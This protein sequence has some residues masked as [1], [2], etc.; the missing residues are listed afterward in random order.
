MVQALTEKLIALPFE[1]A[2][3]TIQYVMTLGAAG[4]LAFIQANIVEL[5]VM[6]FMRVAVQPVNFRLQRVLKFRISVQ[7]AQL[8]GSPV[9]IMTPELEAIGLMSDMLRLMYRFSVDAL[10]SVISPIAVV[11]IYLFKCVRVSSHMRHGRPIP[12]ARDARLARCAG[13]RAI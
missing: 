11:V 10:G 13:Q 9:P 3:Q 7:Q 6:V 12:T 2:L 4:F 8:S 5:S 1:C